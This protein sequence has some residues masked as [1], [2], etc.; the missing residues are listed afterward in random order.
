M[1]IIGRIL[2]I[3]SA[4]YLVVMP[5]LLTGRT[6]GTICSDVRIVIADTADYYLVTDREILDLVNSGALFPVGK[7]FREIS[8][9]TIEARISTLR[10][11][12]T[13]EV[14][15][16]VDGILHVY[17]DQRNPIMRVFA[18]G[19]DY[20]VDD[21]GVVIRRKRLYTP[22]LHIVEGDITISRAMLNGVSVLDTSVKKSVLKDVYRLVTYL[23]NDQFWSAQ[24]DQLHVGGD[25]RIVLIPRL[26][27]HVIHFGT[28]ENLQGK[29]RN[30]GTFYREVMP[31][32]G[33]NMYESVN[34]EFR[35]QI[36]CRRR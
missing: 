9:G 19:G 3:V 31:V 5:A 33:W 18:G 14:Y 23:R 11:L 21:E 10:E 32:T 17:A 6:M 27:N 24:I 26:G 25:G 35:D 12:K 8:L 7:R 1:R 2:I 28:T 30:L 36:V 13:A 22:R 4:L 15:T 34:L 16:T 20:F 29:L